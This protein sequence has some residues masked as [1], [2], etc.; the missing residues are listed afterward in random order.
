[1]SPQWLAVVTALLGFMGSGGLSAVIVAILTRRWKKQDE[2]SVTPE[3]INKLNTQISTLSEKVGK[4]VNAQK[5]I[6]KERV[7]YLG[8]CY[9]YAGK[10]SLD[11]KTTLH[12]MHD[13]YEALGGNGALDTV[14]EEV[15]KLP[16]KGKA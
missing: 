14:M 5:V 8:S 2:Q 3:M 12:E 16:I 9:I 13:A 11:D 6:T 10:V 1:M 4:S 7:R 15:D